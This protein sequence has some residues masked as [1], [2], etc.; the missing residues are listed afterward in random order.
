[1]VMSQLPPVGFRFNM[2]YQSVTGLDTFSFASYVAA[3]NSL[4]FVSYDKVRRSG[5]LFAYML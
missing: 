2:Q 3:D 5:C 4:N 1:M